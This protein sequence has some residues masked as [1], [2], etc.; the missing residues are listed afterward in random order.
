MENIGY[1]LFL[2]DF[3]TPLD[4][5]NYTKNFIYL[6]AEWRIVR[7]YEQ[8]VTY[9][10]KYGLP[11]MISF[12]HD[13]ADVHYEMCDQGL[14]FNYDDMDEKTGYHCAKWIVDYCMD[15]GYIELPRYLIHTQNT[16]GLDNIKSLFENYTKHRND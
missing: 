8:F 15:M 6:T 13:L 5:F 16:V 1:N 14:P 4:V 7:S 12:D 11:S 3:R 10:L 2:D 9:I